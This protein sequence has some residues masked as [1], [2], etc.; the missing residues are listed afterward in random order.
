MHES[1]SAERPDGDQLLMTLIRCSGVYYYTVPSFPV[2]NATLRGI[3]YECEDQEGCVQVVDGFIRDEP[4]L[5]SVKFPTSV[6]LIRN[7]QNAFFV[8]VS[9]LL[10]HVVL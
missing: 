10:Y 8:D 7:C 5:S 3:Q 1:K 9:M 2:F 4:G 6:Y